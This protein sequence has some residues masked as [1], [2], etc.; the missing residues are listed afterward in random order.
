MTYV[1]IT[2]TL[3][4][5]GIA[6]IFDKK[7][8]ASSSP[9]S[10]FLAFHFFSM[11]MVAGL[12]VALPSVY[13]DWHLAKGVLFWEGLNSLAA[14]IALVTYFWAM[15]KAQAS[16]VLGITAGYP[17]VS[18][19]LAVPI[20][21]EPLSASRVIAAVLV[22]LGVAAI[23]YSASSEQKQLT[24]RDRVLVSF[25]IITTTILWALL[26]IFEKQSLSFGRPLEAYLALSIW[27]SLLVVAAMG[28][29]LLKKQPLGLANRS[30]WKFSWL[31]AALVA[32]GNLGFIF[33]LT[34][35]DA[36]YLIVMTAAYPLVMYLAALLFLKEKLSFFRA[37][38]I[39]LIVAGAVL[40]EV[41]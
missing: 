7:A 8:V 37:L 29:F 14:L 25:A 2:I 27:K 11:L 10:V 13:G 39:A 20:L 17:I 23:G 5:W 15:S 31:S 30:T 41:L 38:G 4:S 26:G 32:A 1:L 18:Q 6:G 12:L 33:A 19:L 24:R 9:K 36:N 22:S 34:G 35:T 28:W 3:M 21:H 40:I 16:Y